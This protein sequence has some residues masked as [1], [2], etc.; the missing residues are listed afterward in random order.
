MQFGLLQIFQ[1]HRSALDDAGMWREEIAMALDAEELGLDSVWVVEHHFRDYAACPDNLQYLAYLAART[2]RIRLA[3]GA[4]ILPWN[5]PLRVAEKLSVLDHLSDGR[6]I[7]GMGRGL[8]RREY[9][10]FGIDMESSR[11][12]FDE[13]ADAILA[14]LD[15]GW[16]ECNGRYYQRERTEIRPRPRA[17]FRDRVYAIAM[18]PDSVEAAARIGAGMAIFSQ[19]AWPAARESIQRYRDLFSAQ[20][21]AKVIPPVLTADMIVCDED[22]GRAEAMAR[23]Y[24]GGY[25]LTVFDHYE[26]M[27][28]HLKKARGYEMYGNSVDLLRAIGLENVVENYVQVQAWGTPQ[29]IVDKL[30]E[31]REII[32]DFVFNGCF[33]FAGIPA[34]YARRSMRLFAEQVIP[35]FR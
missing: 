20:H 30:H 10:G 27:S 15:T 35:K 5:D 2:R 13:A 14:A 16:F 9:A 29:M 19:A 25:L 7:F 1:N 32:G 34:D 26:L 21:P 28:D 33:R 22:A 6:A 8:A 12:R 24:V 3:T 31:R 18:S 11:D 4:V 23:E 17:G